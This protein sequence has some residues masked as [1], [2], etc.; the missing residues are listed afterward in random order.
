MKTYNPFK[1]A[2]WTK[3]NLLP[4]KEELAQVKGE[5]AKAG[6]HF[7]DA[8]QDFKQAGQQFDSALE[9]TIAEKKRRKKLKRMKKH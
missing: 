3:A 5:F 9:V 4:S 6:E 1:K 7:K 2:Y 8:G